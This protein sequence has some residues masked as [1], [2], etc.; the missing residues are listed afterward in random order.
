[1]VWA[2]QR[3]A[4]LL[5]RSFPNFPFIGK[6]LALSPHARALLF[7]R[8]PMLSATS[9][10]I[11]VSPCVGRS[12]VTSGGRNPMRDGVFPYTLEHMLFEIAPHC[13]KRVLY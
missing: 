5:N 11:W 12:S 2:E 1:V 10:Q 3:Y 7:P 4:C 9:L 13:T 8:F 6:L